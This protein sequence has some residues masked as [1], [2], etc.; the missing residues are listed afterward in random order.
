MLLKSTA[1][2]IKEYNINWWEAMTGPFA[3]EYW[4]AAYTEIETLEKIGYCYMFDMTD[5]MNAIDCTWDFKIKRFLDGLINK[6][7]A[8]FCAFGLEQLE[9]VDF[10][11]TYARLCNGI[12]FV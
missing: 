3:D 4:K 2:E 12:L 7:K 10:F 5:D 11:E 9:D 6:F 1:E 8:C